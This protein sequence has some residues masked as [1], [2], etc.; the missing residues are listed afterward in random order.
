LNA[1]A[2]SET[3]TFAYQSTATVDLG[4]FMKRAK[5]AKSGEASQTSTLLA[6]VSGAWKVTPIETGGPLRWSAVSIEN[7]EVRLSSGG[8]VLTTASLQIQGVLSKPFF[9]QSD[10]QGA[11]KSLAFGTEWPGNARDIVRTLASLNQFVV[12]TEDAYREGSWTAEEGAPSASY[13]VAYRREGPAVYSR[14]RTDAKQIRGENFAMPTPAAMSGALKTEVEADGHIK[15][16]SGTWTHD[17]VF[18]G[19]KMSHEQTDFSMQR[20]AS[21]EPN[22]SDIKAF[23]ALL[24]KYEG[25]DAPLGVSEYRLAADQAN[26]VAQQTL[27][28]A[29]RN[30]LVTALRQLGSSKAADHEVSKTV[31]KVKALLGL[32]PRSAEAIANVALGA[33]AE[34]P[35]FGAAVMALSEADRPE[36][37]AALCGVLVR[38]KTDLAAVRA[39]T[40][41]FGEIKNPSLASEIAI[42][43]LSKSLDPN[44][45]QS[46]FETLGAMAWQLQNVDSHRS[47]AITLDLTSSLQSESNPATA[48]PMLLALGNAGTP[49]AYKTITPF[50]ASQNPFLRSCA[51]AALRKFHGDEATQLLISKLMTDEVA[52]VRDEAATEL[53]SR[54]FTPTIE[55]GMSILLATTKDDHSKLAVLRVINGKEVGGALKMMVSRM[56]AMDPS[57]QIR[58]AAAAI[59]LGSP[60]GL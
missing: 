4:S 24:G 42:R 25:E 45:R 60:A 17:L 30:S 39:I 8:Q 26:V 20:T 48:G 23:A 12:P 38:R 43:D 59:R 36:A 55:Q 15:N 37:E 22:A 51:L 29:T 19:A 32:D 50:S 33:P 6:N 47:E 44:V 49:L 27:A 28:G 13:R 57:A 11:V 40:L 21:E 2:R 1:V 41:A 14:T 58:K 46:A 5:L 9:I 10:A 53:E 34:S 35:T 16:V 54:P 52:A 3:F 7:P 18:D 31:M 56:S